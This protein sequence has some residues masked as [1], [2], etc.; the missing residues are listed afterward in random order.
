MI[1]VTREADRD[2]EVDVLAL[3]ALSAPSRL[4]GD[5]LGALSPTCEILS[6]CCISGG[7]CGITCLWLS[8][9]G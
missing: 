3:Q 1:E 4:G 2:L 5:G 9:I 7:G 6:R 8:T